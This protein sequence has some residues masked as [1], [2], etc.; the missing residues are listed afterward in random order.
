[1]SNEFCTKS[2]ME[3]VVWALSRN[4]EPAAG[5]AGT[6][7]G[8]QGE[9]QLERTARSRRPGGPCFTLASRGSSWELPPHP[10]IQHI[11]A[12]ILRRWRTPLNSQWSN[13]P[14]LLPASSL[15]TATSSSAVKA[16]APDSS[17]WGFLAFRA[18]GGGGG[19]GGV[20][21]GWGGGAAR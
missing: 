6:S 20:G 5:A 9:G 14:T 2:S 12:S 8:S 3:V 4:S 17:Q 11:S 21:G 19:V 15:P 10:P 18:A 16:A 7:G 13:S 1:M